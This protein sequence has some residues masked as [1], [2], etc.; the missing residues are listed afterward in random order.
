MYLSGNNNSDLF[1]VVHLKFEM[2]PTPQNHNSSK[3]RLKR[4]RG[5]RKVIII[6]S[7]IEKSIS[8]GHIS[9]LRPHL[10]TDF[11]HFYW[12]DVTP[13]P[14]KYTLYYVLM[15]LSP[16]EINAWMGRKRILLGLRNW[17]MYEVAA[18]KAEIYSE[19]SDAMLDVALE[20]RVW[21]ALHATHLILREYKMTIGDYIRW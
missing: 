3:S 2:L 12:T 4:C 6:F 18:A 20:R 16:L 14:P 10:S 17:C 11:N 8:A 5:R 21:N 19:H 15:Q 13:H 7:S 1:T 9:G